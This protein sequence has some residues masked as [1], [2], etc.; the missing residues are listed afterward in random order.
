[1]A[2]DLADDTIE[3]ETH[4]D[5]LPPPPTQRLTIGGYDILEEIGSGGMGVVYRARHRQLGRTVALKLL[6]A[7]AL[8]GP[9]ERQRFLREARV[10]AGLQHPSIVQVFEVGE[11]EGCPYL[12]LEYVP[13]ET[14]ARRLVAGPDAGPVAPG[15]RA[16]LQILLDGD[17][18]KRAAPL[19]DMGNAEAHDVLGCPAG[20]ALAAKTDFSLSAHHAAERTQHRRLAGSVGAQEGADAAFVEHKPDPE[21]R[22]LLAVERIE[23]FRLEHHRDDPSRAAGP[24]PR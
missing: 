24:V 21:Q 11:Y 15:H 20:D 16:E 3:V 14:L 2:H 8:A 7:G 23:M 22:L 17:A 13:N 10:G 9:A 18:Q 12:A 1:M 5:D 6:R 4:A 19:G